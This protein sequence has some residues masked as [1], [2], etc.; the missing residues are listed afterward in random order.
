M[1]GRYTYRDFDRAEVFLFNRQTNGQNC[2]S[3]AVAPGQIFGAD[4][5]VERTPY[6]EV[7]NRVAV[8]NL[9]ADTQHTIA[10]V[11]YSSNGAPLAFGCIDNQRVA[12]GI[13]EYRPPGNRS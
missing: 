12:G 13:D 9:G 11:A 8:N 10:A 2:A 5:V 1:T 3:L 7:D 4:L 6:D